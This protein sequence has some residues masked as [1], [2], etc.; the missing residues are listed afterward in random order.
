[1]KRPSGNQLTILILSILVLIACFGAF[2]EFSFKPFSASLHNMAMADDAE[3]ARQLCDYVSQRIK[4]SEKSLPDI[5]QSP[6]FW[7]VGRNS[8]RLEIYRITNPGIQEQI[9]AAV[10]EW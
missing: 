2:Y 9:F 10:K 4:I 6:V 1:M 8:A 7:D 3:R 5:N